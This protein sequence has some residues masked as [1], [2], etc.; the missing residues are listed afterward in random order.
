[1][2]SKVGF[3]IPEE[4]NVTLYYKEVSVNGLMHLY[5]FVRSTNARTAN[6]SV[7]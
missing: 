4:K 1:M 5:V 3:K 2:L 6:L 7:I